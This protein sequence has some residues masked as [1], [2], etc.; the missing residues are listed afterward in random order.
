MIVGIIVV[1]FIIFIFIS[2]SNVI[3]QISSHE[4]MTK[5]HSDNYGYGNFKKFQTE[6][7]KKNWEISK[8]WNNS[9]FH[10]P[11]NSEIHASIIKFDGIG[12]VISNPIDYIKVQKMLNRIYK[13]EQNKINANEPSKRIH[14]W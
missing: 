11:S 14:K 1:F 13:E 9:F 10:H 8:T 2:F 6:F 4:R 5:K 3:L 12:M 7:Y